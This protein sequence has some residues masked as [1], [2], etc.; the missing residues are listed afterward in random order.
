M[1]LFE[2]FE[3]PEEL[4]EFSCRLLVKAI[5]ILLSPFTKLDWLFSKAQFLEVGLILGKSDN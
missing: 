5:A 3:S 1:K 2:S 4:E